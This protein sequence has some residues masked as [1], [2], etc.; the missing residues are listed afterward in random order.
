MRQVDCGQSGS[1]SPTS[2]P[3]LFTCEAC[4]ERYEVRLRQPGGLCLLC[5]EEAQREQ[6]RLA[7]ALQAAHLPLRLAGRKSWSDLPGPANYL[8]AV[9]KVR[10]FVEHRTSIL[11]VIGNRGLGKSQVGCVSVAETIQAR[12]SAKLVGR[13]Q[14]LADLHQR[15][16]QGGDSRQAW[17]RDWAHPH[18]LVVDELGLGCSTEHDR[19]AFTAL[20]L[21]RFERERPT[22]LLGAVSRENLPEVLD[23]SVLSRATDGGGVVEFVGWR[24]WREQG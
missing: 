3:E 2:S 20:L 10:R 23:A 15:Y 18:L 17:L 6:L 22:L 16:S 12:R 7:E 1:T 21:D 5:F 13:F 9:G 11:V 4:R 8:N 24:S 19:D 14:L